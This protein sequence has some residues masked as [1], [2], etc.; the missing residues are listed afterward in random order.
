MHLNCRLCD[1]RG[2]LIDRRIDQRSR[3]L[4]DDQ[5]GD[6]PVQKPKTRRIAHHLTHPSP[7]RKGRK[8]AG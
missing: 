5:G 1:I 2:V 3:E 6:E 8:D 4:E 7:G